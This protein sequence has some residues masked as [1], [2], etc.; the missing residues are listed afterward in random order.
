MIQEGGSQS[1]VLN[2]QRA[3]QCHYVV[4]AWNPSGEYAQPNAN[5]RHGEAYLVA[6]ITS[7][8]PT[9]DP[10]E[11]KDRY[12]VRFSDY[13]IPPSQKIVWGGMRNPVSYTTLT[14]L[15]L[16]PSTL[17]FELPTRHATHDAPPR[18]VTRRSGAKDD[19]PL[20]IAAAKRGLALQYDVKPEE[21]EIII[22]G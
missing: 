9:D 22:R 8:E 13:A 7:V 5:L 1:W 10:H 6:P 15:G 11:P 3:R 21:I 17:T 4:C 14:A 18:T 20:T 12:I 16:D 19:V 2:L